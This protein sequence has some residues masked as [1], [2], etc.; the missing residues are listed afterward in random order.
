MPTIFVY[1]NKDGWRSIKAKTLTFP[2]DVRTTTHTTT[3]IS[4]AIRDRDFVDLLSES[5]TAIVQ[6][7]SKT[8]KEKKKKT[9]E[10]KN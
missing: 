8:T 7:S 3:R 6:V 4:S 2:L 9:K 1:R 5:I 10:K